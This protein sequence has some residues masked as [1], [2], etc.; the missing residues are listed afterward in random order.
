LWNKNQ[1]LV[2]AIRMVP[3]NRFR[4]AY[5][6]W[7]NK[8]KQNKFNS[9]NKY[10]LIHKSIPA[11]KYSWIYLTCIYL[12]RLF[13]FAIVAAHVSPHSGDKCEVS[14]IFVNVSVRL[15]NWSCK[16]PSVGS[17]QGSILSW[18]IAPFSNNPK[19]SE[20]S[21]PWMT[22]AS[23]SSRSH[24]RSTY[25]VPPWVIIRMFSGSVVSG[26]LW[27]LFE[28]KLDK[29]ITSCKFKG[30]TRSHVLSA[31]VNSIVKQMN[32][33]WRTP[34]YVYEI[35]HDLLHRLVC[36]ISSVYVHALQFPPGKLNKASLPFHRNSVIIIFQVEFY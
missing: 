26:I 34:W 17:M 7:L 3:I 19:G 18:A 29:L 33:P 22:K 1:H 28:S 35:S 6:K 8:S 14:L 24:F 20:G 12:N 25:S 9:L 30:K 16:L 4:K 23:V 13:I 27:L 21:K 36:R 15:G 10:K 32:Q 5:F 11:D 2:D 31:H